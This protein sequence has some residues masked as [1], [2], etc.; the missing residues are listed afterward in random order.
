M[1]TIGISVDILLMSP[2]SSLLSM[3]APVDANSVPQT[4]VPGRLLSIDGDS[5]RNAWRLQFLK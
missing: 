4:D 1:P 2:V 3:Y 5:K